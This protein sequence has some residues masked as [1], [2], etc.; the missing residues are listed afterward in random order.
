MT[1]FVIHLA[2]GKVYEKYNKI[3]DIQGFEK[4]L[5]APDLSK[6]KAE[7][8]Y[9]AHSSKPN[10][11]RFVKEHGISNDFDEGYFIHLLSDYLFYNKF[12]EKWDRSIYNDYDILNE[13]IEKRYSFYLPKELRYV[14]NE[15]KGELSILNE[16]EIYKFIDTVGKINVRDLYKKIEKNH[17]DIIDDIKF[18]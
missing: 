12:L 16:K 7:T 5:I 2:I 17:K 18:R 10:L 15:P 14:L 3:N 8:H 9:G 6:N 1:G 13:K 4:G 11:N